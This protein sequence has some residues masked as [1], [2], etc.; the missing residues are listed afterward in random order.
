MISPVIQDFPV[1]IAVV[2]HDK[3]VSHDEPIVVVAA[4]IIAMLHHI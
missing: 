3:L 2:T 4:V 1:A